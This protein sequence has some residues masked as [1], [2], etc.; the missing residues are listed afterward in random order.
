MVLHFAKEQLRELFKLSAQPL[1]LSIQSF[2]IATFEQLQ[3]QHLALCE[4]R[5][6][7]AS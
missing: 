7:S 6:C 3:E 4:Y 2:V 5:G 1:A